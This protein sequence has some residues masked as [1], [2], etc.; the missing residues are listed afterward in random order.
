MKM[1][2]VFRCA[3][4]GRNR[5]EQLLLLLL[6]V[7]LISDSCINSFSDEKPTLVH[8]TY[9]LCPAPVIEDAGQ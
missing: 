3:W 2:C 4:D 1:S 7:F 8:D 9:L 5:K 6:E